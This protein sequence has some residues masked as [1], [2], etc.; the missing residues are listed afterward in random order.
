[1]VEVAGDE[2]ELLAALRPDIYLPA[3]RPH[4]GTGYEPPYAL[5][6]ADDLA[7]DSGMSSR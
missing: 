4:D 2:A 1:M 3:D 6:A 5:A 7:A